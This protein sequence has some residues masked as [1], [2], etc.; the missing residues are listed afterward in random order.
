MWEERSFQHNNITAKTSALS[1]G[2]QDWFGQIVSASNLDA[3]KGELTN[4]ISS[5]IETVLS[6][7]F[8]H[9]KKLLYDLL[10]S[11]Q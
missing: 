4:I 3:L 5:N 6:V 11:F 9:K 10:I 1:Q 8:L 7:N 2:Y